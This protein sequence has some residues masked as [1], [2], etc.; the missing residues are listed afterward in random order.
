MK[1]IRESTSLVKKTEHYNVTFKP[2]NIPFECLE[3]LGI[4]TVTYHITRHLF[5]LHIRKS[6]AT[7]HGQISFGAL[8]CVFWILPTHMSKSTCSSFSAMKHYSPE[9]SAKL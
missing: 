5:V 7:N 8:L 2:E 3:P 9:N 6:W 4:L 1:A